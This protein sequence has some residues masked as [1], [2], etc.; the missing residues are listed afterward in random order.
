V[1]LNPSGRAI[2]VVP[3]SEMG[4]YTWW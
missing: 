4:Y 2:H 1:R 3:K